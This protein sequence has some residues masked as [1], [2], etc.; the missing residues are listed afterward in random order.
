MSSDEAWYSISFK[1]FN[2]DDYMDIATFFT[3]EIVLSEGHPINSAYGFCKHKEN[4]ELDFVFS[5]SEN[6]MPH[7]LMGVFRTDRNFT[8]D[9]QNIDENRKGNLSLS[10]KQDLHFTTTMEEFP[11]AALHSKKVKLDEF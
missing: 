5:Q 7:Y 3:S 8:I 9:T 11:Q 6:Y 10:N 1:N 2:Y 4:D